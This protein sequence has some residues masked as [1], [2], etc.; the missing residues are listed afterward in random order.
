MKKI[1]YFLLF[2]FFFL[3][4]AKSQN[5]TWTDG[6]ACIIYSHCTSCHNANG[7]APFSLTTYSD[8]FLHRYSIA[9]A[10]AD[11]RMPPFP[12]NQDKQKYAHTNTLT[13]TEIQQ[14]QDWVANAA[15]LGNASNVP[16][17]P[18]YNTNYQLTN[19]DLVKQI[20]NFTVNTATDLYRCFVLPVNNST[21]QMI[22]SLEVVPGDRSIVHHVLVYQDTSSIP[23]NLDLADPL[24]GYT[25]FGGTAS[26]SSQLISGYTPGQG[27]FNFAPGFGAKL[28][29]NS[30]IVLQIHYPGGTSNGLDSTQIR[31]KYG[32][33]SLRN[34]TTAP[35]LNHTTSL[36]NGPLFIPANTVKTFYS[37]VT[38]P[39]NLTLTG[40]MPHMHL[41][42]TKIK[43]YCIKP[44]GDTIHLID[45]PKWDFHWQ[46]FYQF[47]K[48]ILIPQGSIIRGEATYDNTSSNPNNPNNPPHDVSLGESTT[49]EMMLIYFN[50]SAYQPG[51]TSIIVD[52]SS[53]FAHYG[54]C[55]SNAFPLSI[56]SFTGAINNNIT[57]LQWQVENEQDVKNYAIERSVDGIH[58]SA[59]G[60]KNALNTSSVWY[61][62]TDNIEGL[63]NPIVYY[64][65][66]QMNKSAEIFYSN[67]IL[68]Q[69]QQ[70][71]N[72][73][74]L[75][76]PN[77]AT[78][79][80]YV[81][82]NSLSR[83]DGTIAIYCTAGKVVY[84][85]ICKIQKGN[86][87]IS[88]NDLNKLPKG[89]YFIEVQMEN[90]KLNG[91][92]VK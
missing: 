14:L 7:I 58:F 21:Q 36:T 62:F 28:L 71:E 1:F 55:N 53:H 42:G 18:V 80:V 73:Q 59:V 61:S 78:N 29:P 49:D 85:R 43:A 6:V 9:N 3:Q 20:P 17:P 30:Y 25:A 27:V 44:T 37:K 84:S 90:E 31:I 8:A 40:I 22:Q 67:R 76:Y 51:D 24:P 70:K 77:P 32:S 69:T 56:V 48:P 47:Q 87:S 92:F 89:G 52:T 10:T 38:S 79:F 2:F 91:R 35:Y 60:S 72:T 57:E 82:F 5:A 63:Y 26:Q 64:R 86:N 74:L 50:L 23:L 39:Y 12:P 66:K 81:N 4:S 13:A 33:S 34:V 54:Y 83:Q 19:A 46:G 88:I 68:L 45:V 11:K 65:L 75:V 16:T 41:I 15:P